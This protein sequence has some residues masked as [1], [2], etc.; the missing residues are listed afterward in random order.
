MD[1]V[2]Y[3]KHQNL[4]QYSR[5]NVYEIQDGDK[6]YFVNIAHIRKYFQIYHYDV[7]YYETVYIIDP[8]KSLTMRIPQTKFLLELNTYPINPRDVLINIRPR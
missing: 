2:D 4:A 7:R 6:I 5:H 1:T 8:T 3:S